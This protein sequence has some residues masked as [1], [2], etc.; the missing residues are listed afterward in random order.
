MKPTT[1]C[2]RLPWVSLSQGTWVKWMGTQK[3]IS[4][5]SFSI[6]MAEIVVVAVIKTAVKD[7]VSGLRVMTEIYVL[8][9]RTAQ[10]LLG[11]EIV[12]WPVSRVLMTFCWI[13]LW[14]KFRFSCPHWRL[15]VWQI[16]CGKHCAAVQDTKRS[17][18]FTWMKQNSSSYEL[19]SRANSSFWLF[20]ERSCFQKEDIL[21]RGKPISLEQKLKVDRR[22][23]GHFVF[24]L[25]D[26][27]PFLYLTWKSALISEVWIATQALDVDQFDVPSYVPHIV[28]GWNLRPRRRALNTMSLR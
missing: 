9:V 16:W 2:T 8:R 22:H 13:I 12:N 11:A 18:C 27:A 20:S 5:P 28:W 4:A 25:F 1:I 7:Y 21:E 14:C 15:F 3:F 17:I 24:S 6:F 23:T 19:L 10:I 26:N